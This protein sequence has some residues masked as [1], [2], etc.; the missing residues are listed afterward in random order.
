MSM[1]PILL[2]FNL[3]ASWFVAHSFVQYF[4]EGDIKKRIFNHFYL[5]IIIIISFMLGQL[6][7]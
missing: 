2:M 7:N 3:L 1:I 5:F 4:L 6:A